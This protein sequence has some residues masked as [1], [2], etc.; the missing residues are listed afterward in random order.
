[1]KHIRNAISFLPSWSMLRNLTIALGVEDGIMCERINR[2]IDSTT[3]QVS[4]LHNG[5][6]RKTQTL[7]H[8]SMFNFSSYLQ[9]S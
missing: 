8:K 3:D 1:M 7:R 9:R 4:L 2:L 5:G 6:F